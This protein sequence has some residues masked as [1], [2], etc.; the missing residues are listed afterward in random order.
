ME[1][2]ARETIDY[3]LAG[4]SLQDIVNYNEV[5]VLQ[6]M[7]EVLSQDLT[8]CQCCFCVEDVYALSLNALPS[9]YLQPSSVRT[10]QASGDFISAETVREKVKEAVAWVAKKPNHD[11]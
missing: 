1:L 11:P 2:M 6:V 9:R 7:R 5:L 8:L 10:Y 4:H 3:R